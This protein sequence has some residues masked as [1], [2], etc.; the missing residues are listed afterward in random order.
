MSKI[1]KLIRESRKYEYRTLD[2]Y[3]TADPVMHKLLSDEIEIEMKNIGS[4]NKT[5]IKKELMK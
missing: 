2:G 1:L 5:L 4:K 3:K